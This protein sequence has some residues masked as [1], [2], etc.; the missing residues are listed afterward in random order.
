MFMVALKIPSPTLDELSSL[1]SQN[2]FPPNSTN[3]IAV[4]FNAGLSPGMALMEVDSSASK[5]HLSPPSVTLR[6]IS[7]SPGATIIVDVPEESV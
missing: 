7:Q 4:R 6:R 3:F 2:T 1:K 5:I